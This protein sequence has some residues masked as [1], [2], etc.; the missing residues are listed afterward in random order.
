MA[1]GRVHVRSG[2]WTRT[3]LLVAAS[4]GCSNDAEVEALKSEVVATYA[5]IVFASYEDAFARARELESVIAAFV[6]AP[7]PEGLDAA[8]VAWLAARERYGPT[9]AY[10]FYGGPIDDTDGPETLINAWPL[11]EAYIDYVAGSPAGGIVNDPVAYPEISAAAL[12]SLNQSGSEENVSV[13]Y[14]AIEFLI[15]G[16]DVSQDGPG[17]RPYTD[18]VKGVGANAERRSEYLRVVT[19]MLVGHLEEVVAAWDPANRASYRAELTAMPADQALQRMLVGIG[20]LS[21][22]ELAGE[23]IFTAYDNQDQ[24]DEHSC[25]SDNTH[26]DIALNAEG[27]ANVIRGTYVRLDGT[28]IDGPGLDDLLQAVSPEEAAELSALLDRSLLAVAAI[29]QPFDRAITDPGS[30][31]LV[32]EAVYALQDQGDKIA[33]VGTLLGL[34]I[35]TALPE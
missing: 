11:D 2:K 35:N 28:R 14:H 32:L 7:S 19:E 34:T 33:E 30:R 31:P 25:F 15:W 20:V 6:E 17:A 26:R 4:A 13:G 27:I 22:S 18:F 1:E 3:A 29:P 16:Q 8:K 21:K 9:E 12:L 10:R 24:E 5:D 23:R